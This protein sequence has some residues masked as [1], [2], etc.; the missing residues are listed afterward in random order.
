[1]ADPVIL[2]ELIDASVARA[3]M[4]HSTF[5]DATEQ[6]RDVQGSA[7][8]LYDLVLSHWGEDYYHKTAGLVTTPNLETVA[9][10]ADFYKLLGVDWCPAASIVVFDPQNDIWIVQSYGTPK[11]ELDRFEWL[12]RNDYQAGTGW[13]EWTRPRYRQRAGNLWLAPTPTQRYALQLHYVPVCQL[14]DNELHPFDA[15]NGW[16]EY[17]AVRTAIKWRLNEESDVTGLMAELA[18]LTRRIEAMAPKRDLGR[19]HKVQLVRARSRFNRG[20]IG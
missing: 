6:E 14:V 13:T 17:I 4:K 11:W 20:P 7:K 19:P 18:L 15:V 12:E 3:G 10:P 9:L 2:Q 1:M 8:E 5:L 16:Q